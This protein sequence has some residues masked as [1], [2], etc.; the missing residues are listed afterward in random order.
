M[1]NH[2]RYRI[3]I[4]ADPE[5]KG[6][7]QETTLLLFCRNEAAVKHALSNAKA[8]RTDRISAKV[9]EAYYNGTPYFSLFFDRQVFVEIF[10]P[11]IDYNKYLW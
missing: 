11:K 2:T 5:K 7:I 8:L 10:L 4:Y 6:L 3:K 9:Y 1:S